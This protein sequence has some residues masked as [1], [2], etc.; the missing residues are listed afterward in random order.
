[1]STALPFRRAA[2]TSFWT[3]YRLLAVRPVMKAVWLS[4]N[5]SYSI[6]VRGQGD[7]YDTYGLGAEDVV[8]LVTAIQ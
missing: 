1:M 2:T 6:T 4:D 3:S 8:A 7:L 5:F